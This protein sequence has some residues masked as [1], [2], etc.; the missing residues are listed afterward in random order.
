MKKNLLRA[1]CILTVI[2]LVSVL[3]ASCDNPFSSKDPIPE[4]VKLKTD[5]RDASFTF[6][7]GE[8]KKVIPLDAL[9][10][11]F[12]NYEEKN[13]DTEITLSHN[14]IVTRFSADA[15]K[16]D[17]KALEGVWSLAEKDEL[18]ALTANKN[19]VID[20]FNEHANALKKEKPRTEFDE[21]FWTDDSSDTI[22]ISKNGAELDKDSDEYKSIRG[23]AI[24]YKNYLLEGAQSKMLGHT[25]G[26]NGEDFTATKKGQSLDDYLYLQ[27]ESTVSKLTYDDVTEAISSLKP[28]I[29]TVNGED[30]ITGYTRTIVLKLKPE[31]ESVLKAFS[32]HN[33]KAVLDEMKKSDDYFKV[34]DYDLSFGECVI[35]AVIN[36]VTDEVVSL[37]YQKNMTVNASFT[38]ANNFA[39]LGKIDMTFNCTNQIYYHF[40]RTTQES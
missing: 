19:D 37:T 10:S 8:L 9:A 6:T 11:L 28:E 29:T 35:T 2:S 3:F 38:G 13:P 32:L 25:K 4:E 21:A 17:G 15:M 5:L 7:Y 30:Y 26:E 33:K 27:G 23:G 24:I 14:E 31:R 1:V 16:D 39:S 18:D 40:D 34:E 12:E 20:Y 22:N 36:G